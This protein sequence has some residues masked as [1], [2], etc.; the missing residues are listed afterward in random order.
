MK[1][2]LIITWWEFIRHFKSRS[3][4]L[5]TFIS[6]LI[7]GLVIFVT[8]YYLQDYPQDR[9]RLV[10]CLEVD[11]TGVC[12]SIH[13]RFT[14]LSIASTALPKIEFISI[15]TDTSREMKKR[16]EQ[17]SELKVELDSLE[18]SYNTIKERRKYIFQ[19]PKTSERERSLKVSYDNLLQTREARDLAQIGFQK[20]KQFT[21]SLWQIETI[22]HADDLLHSQELEGYL[23]IEPDNFAAGLVEL[24]S[25]W[26]ANFLEIEPLKQAVQVVIVEQRLI[27]EDLRVDKIQEWLEPI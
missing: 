24:H 9:L 26:P 22:R 8:N 25:L 21:D 18:D 12:Q 1:A 11:T 2:F 16:F 19:K 15:R 5:S 14:E 6:P 3:F 4:I 23:L 27:K 7:F 17:V 13:Q 10:G 20:T